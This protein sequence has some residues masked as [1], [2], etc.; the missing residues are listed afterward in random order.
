MCGGGKG[1]GD[2][3]EI[4]DSPFEAEEKLRSAGKAG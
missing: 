2:E 3:A 1:G 4:R